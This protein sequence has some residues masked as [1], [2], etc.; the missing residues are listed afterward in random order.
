[1]KLLAA[2][3]AATVL[4]S[5]ATLQA[6][7]LT[8]VINVTTKAWKYSADN[9]DQYAAGFPN[10]DDSAWPEGLP[11]FGNDTTINYRYPFVTTVA[12]SG[13]GVQT[14]YYRTRFNWVGSTTGVVLTMT[15]MID[16]GIVIFINGTEIMRWNVNSAPGIPL[17]H[18]IQ[19]TAANP[20]GEPNILTHQV[21]LDAL[22]NGNVNPLIAGEN[23]IAVAVHQAGTGSSDSVFGLSVHYSQS[24]PPC[25]PTVA[26]ASIAG[27]ECKEATFTATLAADCGVPAPSLQ[28]YHDGV[29][30]PGATGLGLTLS[31]LTTAA[32]GQYT[33]RASNVAGSRDSA[34]V[35]LTVAADTQGP[36]IVS[37]VN[38]IG[39]GDQ[40][41]VTFD[42]PY[43]LF[44][45]GGTADDAFTW[46]I[47][48]TGSPLT[49]LG[50]VSAVAEPNSPTQVRI[51]VDAALTDGVPYS[52]LTA[53][54]IADT[55]TGAST[56]AGQ[57]GP[58]LR[59]AQLVHWTDN[60]DWRYE[61]SG[62]NQGSAWIAT[63]FDDSA[64][65]VG[66]QGF[67]N[68]TPNFP[69]APDSQRTAL[70]VST[71]QIT[72][73]FRTKFRVPT[74]AQDVRFSAAVDDGAII[75]VNGTE[76]G[77]INVQ[78]GA[79]AFDTLVP[80]I[81]EGQGY[82]PAT[83]ILI[84]NSI[85]NFGNVDNVL[86]IEVHQSSTTSSDILLLA[87]ITAAVANVTV[88]PPQILTQ[89]S[90]VSVAEGRSFSLT[91]VASPGGVTYQ[92]S[93]DGV[94][95]PGANAA[96]YTATAD[97]TSGGVY[98]VKVSNSAGNVTSDPATVALRRLVVPYS[99]VWKYET[100][101]Q[102]GTLTAPAPW[103]ASAF[104]DAAWQS[105][106]GP[107]GIETTAAT[108]ARL[109]TPIA[110]PLPP[111]AAT[112]LTTYFRSALTA[113]AV[114]AGQSL[115]LSHIIDDGAIFYLDG[116][117]VYSYN[118][119]GGQPVVCTNVAPAAVP[120][121][122]DA[123]E[124]TVPISIPAGAHVVAVEVHQNSPTSS[125]VVF[126]VELTVG[127]AFPKLTITHPTPTTVQVS[128]TPAVGVRLFESATVNG[129]YTAVA[130]NP[131]GTY[132]ATLPAG[133]AG[134]FFQLKFN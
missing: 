130:G 77:R 115:Y 71:T 61:A 110:T 83:G 89:P 31:N 69:D 1:M 129:V 81:T 2:L 75:Y 36:R 10:V 116:V 35:T 5:M 63:G 47:F 66:P 30:I 40:I 98:R 114:P 86:A 82:L 46:S 23:I 104:V 106:P 95:I 117:P 127:P 112:Y 64:W 109:P 78:A 54:A 8:E 121:D 65:A 49:P 101:C 99:S 57:T 125:D 56:P 41:L 80:N 88:E 51:T 29:A 14:S 45:N 4:T 52:Y 59:T 126:G 28:W 119:S 32:A 18:D 13:G 85:L 122:G 17:A 9:S 44:A 132:T 90:S 103:Y 105:G 7:S 25:T 123:R 27:I 113:T 72:Y 102:D 60:R 91:V 133:T 67:G 42:E 48:P 94:D 118:M 131:Q 100:N 96:T 6:Q 124:V 16:D 97:A 84:P 74:G 15:N 3:V 93:K 53:E 68:E 128:W 55:C 12:G 38:V 21:A 79:V 50:I 70:T 19:A 43:L 20:L 108:L 87:R 22:T 107:F 37:V 73:Y 111:P 11:L 92:W 34:P 120:G 24:V 58:V 39:A 33:V 26:P 76:I 134:H 62:A